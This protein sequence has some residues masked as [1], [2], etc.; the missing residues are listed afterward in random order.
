MG[1]FLFQE[2]SLPKK[3]MKLF[4]H[5]LEF[6]PFCQS[7]YNG[8]KDVTDAYDRLFEEDIGENRFGYMIRQATANTILPDKHSHKRK[9]LVE[10]FGFYRLSFGSAAVVA[11]LII[12][13][14][15][16]MKEPGVEKNPP[17]ELL[18]WDGEKIESK[19]ELI[20]NQII[21]LKSEEWDIYIIRKDK[22]E[23]W[24][25]TLKN[26]W[27]QIDELKKTTN[28]KEL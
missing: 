9:S 25:A 2:G 20:E 19:I 27:N 26:I 15:S 28:R 10:L 1:I 5:H 24:D 6:C 8:L 12:I 17:Y 22:R 13:V 3:R 7:V 11:A 16:F 4:K 14:I 23:N 18:D 21:S